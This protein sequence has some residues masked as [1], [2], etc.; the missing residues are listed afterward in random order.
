MTS[1][2]TVHASDLTGIMFADVSKIPANLWRWPNFSPQELACKGSGKIMVDEY[3]LDLLQALRN[4][5]NAPMIVTSAFR[6]PAHNAAVGGA[7]NS[8]HKLA[9]A[10][11]IS[12]GNHDP[13]EFESAARAVGF[14]GFGFYPPKPNGGH[15]FM[16]IDTGR[17]RQWGERW[18]ITK[19]PD[20]DNHDVH[21]AA[22]AN[23]PQVAPFAFG[24]RR[25]KR[26]FAPRP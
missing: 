22:D 26:R 13:A 24:Q 17:A 25:P 20:A 16:H 8:M 3:A 11:D 14:T 5:L 12:Q 19:L 9:R 18:T 6:S 21:G 1:S 7:K 2:E 10:F 4:R 23:S 15:N